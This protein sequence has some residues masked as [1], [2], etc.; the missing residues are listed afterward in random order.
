MQHMITFTASGDGIGN[1]CVKIK[2]TFLDII[3]RITLWILS[4]WTSR[5][6]FPDEGC[7]YVFIVDVIF[8][9][10]WMYISLGFSAHC[11]SCVSCCSVLNHVICLIRNTKF[12]RLGFSDLCVRFLLSAGLMR[13]SFFFLYLVTLKQNFKNVTLYR[14]YVFTLGIQPYRRIY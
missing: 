10:L 13:F 2:Y 11:L 8:I 6:P 12:F 7:C 1:G 14:T 4:K 3:I 5:L 9:F